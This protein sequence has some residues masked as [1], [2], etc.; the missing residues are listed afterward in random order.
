M[1]SAVES[2]SIIDNEGSFNGG[3]DPEVMV[4]LFLC[5]NAN[6]LDALFQWGWG[7][8]PEVMVR[9]ITTSGGFAPPTFQWGHDPEVMV[10]PFLF[11]EEDG[12]WH[13]SMG[14]RPGGHGKY[15]LKLS[16]TWEKLFQWGH[17]PEV[18]VRKQ[19]PKNH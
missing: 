17:D 15:I 13:V 3:H 2:V 19:N 8:D 5:G 12:K 1:V 14:P 10:S 9:P 16:T 6:S 11:T 18:M 4:S 7:H